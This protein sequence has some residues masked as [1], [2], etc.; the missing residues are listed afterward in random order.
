MRVVSANADRAREEALTSTASTG[1][2]SPAINDIDIMMPP[3][4]WPVGPAHDAVSATDNRL[5]LDVSRRIA[6]VANGTSTAPLVTFAEKSAK[7]VKEDR[8]E[9]APP[10]AAQPAQSPPP[11]HARGFGSSARNSRLVVEAGTQRSE[12]VSVQRTTD[13]LKELGREPGPEKIAGPPAPSLP[14]VLLLQGPTA[15]GAPAGGQPSV[16]HLCNTEADWGAGFAKEALEGGGSRW[17][18]AKQCD[19]ERL[20]VAL[21]AN[22]R[23]RSGEQGAAAAVLPFCSNAL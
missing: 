20:R 1:Y 5:Q 10:E 4:C 8:A 7:V 19:E 2:G 23:D 12:I 3:S 11:G 13:V 21:A 16:V 17:A 15:H 9:A 14:F 22:A 6:A 18:L